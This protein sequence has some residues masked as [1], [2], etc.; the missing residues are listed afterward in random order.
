MK[1]LLLTVFL[2][3]LP[4]LVAAEGVSCKTV[5]GVFVLWNGWPPNLRLEDK[6]TKIIY[7]VNEDGKIP[8]EMKKIIEVNQKIS[9]RFCLRVIDQATKVPD[10]KV[11]ITLVDV[12]SYEVN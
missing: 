8:V 9:G 1:K 6:K 5:S 4:A 7:G 3:L 11:P 12:I 10:S 2:A